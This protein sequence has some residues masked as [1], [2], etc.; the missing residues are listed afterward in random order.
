MQFKQRTEHYRR[1]LIF[2]TQGD[3]LTTRLKLFKKMKQYI[4]EIHSNII[5]IHIQIDCRQV[6]HMQF[7]HRKKHFTK[8]MIIIYNYPNKKI[9]T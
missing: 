4:I 9:K 2:N 8:I 7:P 1:K 6:C 3:Q 5:K